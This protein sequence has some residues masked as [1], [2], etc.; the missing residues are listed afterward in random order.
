MCN[1]RKLQSKRAK[2]VTFDCVAFTFILQ[3]HQLSGLLEVAYTQKLKGQEL[4]V[5]KR[6]LQIGIGCVCAPERPQ[7][8]YQTESIN[9]L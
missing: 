5:F 9:H 4:I 2:R 6:N 8:V 1:A 3:C 7:R